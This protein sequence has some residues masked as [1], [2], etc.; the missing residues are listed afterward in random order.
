[1]RV[2]RKKPVVST[3]LSNEGLKYFSQNQEPSMAICPGR[4]YSAAT[5]V[6]FSSGPSTRNGAANI[7]NEEGRSKVVWIWR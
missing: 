3:K 5:V 7:Q 4:F 1:M 6:R 2:S